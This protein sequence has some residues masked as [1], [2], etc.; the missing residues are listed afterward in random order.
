MKR[1]FIYLKTTITGID[2]FI[3]KSFTTKTIKEPL[4]PV[5]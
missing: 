2:D 1:V 5:A 3:E 4:S